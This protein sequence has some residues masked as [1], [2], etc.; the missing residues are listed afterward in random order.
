MRTKSLVDDA[1][2]EGQVY[3]DSDKWLLIRVWELQGLYL[4]TMQKSTFINECSLAESITRARRA[5][6]KKYPASEA[7]DEARYDKYVEGRKSRGSSIYGGM[8][9]SDEEPLDQLSMI[10]GL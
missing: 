9:I 7:V 1:L 2:A 10:G 6:K 5:L 3:R 8:G 4:T